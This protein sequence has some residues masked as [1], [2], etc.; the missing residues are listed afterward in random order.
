M[1]VFAISWSAKLVDGCSQ[2][3]HQQS[4]FCYYFLF[5]GSAADTTALHSTPCSRLKL[6]SSSAESRAV[7]ARLPLQASLHPV[8]VSLVCSS[9]LHRFAA[10]GSPTARQLWGGARPQGVFFF[11][12]RTE[13]NPTRGVPNYL[14]IGS[15]ARSWRTHADKYYTKN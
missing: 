8:L 12:A 3:P 7:A 10:H 5:G 1:T 6:S 14:K 15:S 2:V 11:Y 9:S 4:I 13:N